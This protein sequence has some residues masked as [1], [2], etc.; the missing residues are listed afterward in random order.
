MR[1]PIMRMTIRVMVIMVVMVV[2]MIMVVAFVSAVIVSVMV[3][4]F[5]RDT[6]MA[7]RIE[8]LVV[9]PDFARI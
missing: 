1:M 3:T 9:G 4:A 8:G 6:A 2:L 7:W 5:R